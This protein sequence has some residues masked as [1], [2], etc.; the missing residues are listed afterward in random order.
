MEQQQTQNV[1]LTDEQQLKKSQVKAFI[2]EL[3]KHENDPEYR[4]MMENLRR[5]Q[6]DFKEFMQMPKEQR[7]KILFGIQTQLI[8][9]EIDANPDSPYNWQRRE[10][11][12]GSA[13]KIS[14]SASA[15]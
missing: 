8:R 7:S 9:R 1:E 4:K 11:N 3:E 15:H 6:R 13:T 14:I 2:K 12:D 5:S 10:S